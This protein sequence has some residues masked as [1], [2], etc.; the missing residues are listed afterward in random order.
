M[1]WRPEDEN[2]VKKVFHSKAFHRLS[3]MFM[4]ARRDNKKPNSIGERVWSDL[5]AH[6]NE[7]SYRS[8]RAQAQKNR[9]SEK[10][11]C[12]HTGGSISMQDHAIRLVCKFKKTYKNL[13]LFSLALST[14]I[15]VYFI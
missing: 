7:P 10:G 11:G 8:K 2:K 13:L 14:F 3:E 1:T 4:E 12:M 5:L 15:N 9:A 6:W